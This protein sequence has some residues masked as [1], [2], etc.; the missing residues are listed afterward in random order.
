M[1]FV[2]E[3]ECKD[4]GTIVV[5]AESA[6]E[7]GEEEGG[8]GAAGASDTDEAPSSDGA[9]DSDGGDN[10]DGSDSGITTHNIKQAMMAVLKLY[11]AQGMADQSSSD[12]Q[13]KAGY[14]QDQAE[15]PPG[16]M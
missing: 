10:P 5:S 15:M 13:F 2:I 1:S 16:K 11:K 6:E 7:E 14:G 12:D 4:D 3:L 9:A 8:A